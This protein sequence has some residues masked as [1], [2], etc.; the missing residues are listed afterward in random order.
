MPAVFPNLHSIKI[1]G[2]INP[3]PY[4]TDLV[5]DLTFDEQRGRDQSNYTIADLSSQVVTNSRVFEA[6]RRPQ[7]VRIKNPASVIPLRPSGCAMPGDGYSFVIDRQCGNIGRAK[8]GSPS[9]TLLN[10]TRYSQIVVVFE[11]L[12]KDA[13]V[14]LST[15][16]VGEIVYTDAQTKNVLLTDGEYQEIKFDLIEKS[17]QSDYPFFDAKVT[18]ETS[19]AAKNVYYYDEYR[20]FWKNVVIIQDSPPSWTENPDKTLIF[21]PLHTHNTWD[22]SNMVVTDFSDS[23]NEFN[24]AFF[25]SSHSI[26]G[27]G[28]TEALGRTSRVS[29]ISGNEIFVSEMNFNTIEKDNTGSSYIYNHYGVTTPTTT[30][31]TLGYVIGEVDTLSTWCSTVSGNPQAVGM[32]IGHYVGDIFT[33]DWEVASIAKD[34]ITPGGKHSVHSVSVSYQPDTT[35]WYYVTVTSQTTGTPDEKINNFLYMGD[36]KY[37]ES[38][39][40]CIPGSYTVAN[41]EVTYNATDGFVGKL[42]NFFPTMPTD[43]ESIKTAKLDAGVGPHSINFPTSSDFQIYNMAAPVISGGSKFVIVRPTTTDGNFYI[44]GSTTSPYGDANFYNLPISYYST[45]DAAN[46]TIILARPQEKVYITTGRT[47]NS[48]NNPNVQFFEKAAEITTESLAV[49]GS[50]FD[51]SSL[52]NSSN[53][54]F[55][56]VDFTVPVSGASYSLSINAKNTRNQYDFFASS[57]ETYECPIDDPKCKILKSS[58]DVTFN[59]RNY[60]TFYIYCG[61]PAVIST[62][63]GGTWD[64]LFLVTSGETANLKIGDWAILIRNHDGSNSLKKIKKINHKIHGRIFKSDYV[65]G[66]AN[67]TGKFYYGFIDGGNMQKFDDPT[68]K[69]N[70]GTINAP[71]VR[72]YARKSWSYLRRGWFS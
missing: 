11:G 70:L 27:Y 13:V 15:K 36:R 64:V 52:I 28:T 58:A 40:W 26:G 56:Y 1:N 23:K 60:T 38:Y 53:Y 10:L 50:V 59:D 69:I 20:D 4:A 19:D 55:R 31:L 45:T 67:T 29:A 6:V 14:K 72:L 7:P 39:P 35:Y 2:W 5:T 48:I 24:T 46:E 51:I 9:S 44:R 61:D 47:T 68:Y 12:K 49:S 33:S 37:T 18:L 8:L 63:I 71:R 3:T 66:D 57:D 62:P 25:T 54:N 17:N 22:R 34:H 32:G 16:S 65:W 43:R 41:G 30:R 21:S 42:N